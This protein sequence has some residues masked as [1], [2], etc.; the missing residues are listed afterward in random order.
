MMSIG[1]SARRDLVF[2]SY[3]HADEPPWLGPGSWLRSP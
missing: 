1:E 2:I 3:S